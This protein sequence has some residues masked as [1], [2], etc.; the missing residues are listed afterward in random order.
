MTNRFAVLLRVAS[1]LALTVAALHVARGAETRLIEAGWSPAV[2]TRLE[3]LIGQQAGKKLPVVLDF[4]NTLICRDIAEAAFGVLI[5]RGQITVQSV[6]KTTCP[7]F[8]VGD[9]LVSPERCDLLE[10]YDYLC[11]P[12]PHHRYPDD[13]PDLL[14]FSWLVEIM[15][16]LTPQ[17]VVEA[18]AEAY[19]QGS[20]EQDRWQ[21]P[22]ETRLEISPGKHSFRRPFFQPEMVDLVA[23]LLQNDYE[24]WVI[25]AGNAWSARWLVT[26]VLN[27]K[28]KA[29]GV[30]PGIAPDHVLGITTALIDAEQRLW[31]DPLLVRENSSYANLDPATLRQ[32]Q[33]TTRV[34]QP[35]AGYFGKV[36][37]IQKWIQRQPYLVAGDSLNDMPML[38]A[39]QYRLWV[40]RL[41]KTEYQATA[42]S[43]IRA[44]QPDSWLVQP[45]LYTKSPGFVSQAA[46][47]SSRLPNGNEAVQ[48]SLAELRAAGLLDGF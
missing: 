31:K 11:R 30:T 1:A 27:E 33:I 21:F 35:M 29:R 20:G 6:P 3:Q 22:G 24:V 38:R 47:L 16:G 40:A 44:N 46:A 19:D 42:A 17:D 18:A 26:K 14:S 32:F 25:T 28:L 7:T 37:L 23:A 4:D 39:G 2:R 8:V 41:E 15:A 12:T 45:A 36:A 9:T 43:V 34:D 10:Y 13:S 48:K 5:R